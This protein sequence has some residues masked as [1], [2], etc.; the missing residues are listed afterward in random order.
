VELLQDPRTQGKINW[1]AKPLFYRGKRVFGPWSSGLHMQLL[2]K[3]H[4]G[5]TVINVQLYSDET[6]FYKGESAHPV[7]GNMYNCYVQAHVTTVLQWKAVKLTQVFRLQVPY[8]I[9][10]RKSGWLFLVVSP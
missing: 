2:Q 3:K 8:P 5:K 10:M 1:E 7:F 9:T 6:E 4:P